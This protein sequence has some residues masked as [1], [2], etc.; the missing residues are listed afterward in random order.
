LKLK[1]KQSVHDTVKVAPN[2]R[3][4]WNGLG[5]PDVDQKAL[6]KDGMISWFVSLAAQERV[7]LV[8]QYEVS[9]ADGL[10]IEGV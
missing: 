6:G 10:A 3:A 1:T 8:L 5:E 7:T 9:H 4:Q 2:V